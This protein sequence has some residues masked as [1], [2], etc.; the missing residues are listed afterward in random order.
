[1]RFWADGR[2]SVTP[3]FGERYLSTILFEELRKEA[4][5][6]AAMPIAE[7]AAPQA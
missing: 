5:A 1:V 3:S 6:L 4:Q 2:P 7:S